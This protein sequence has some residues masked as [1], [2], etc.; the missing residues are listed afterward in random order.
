MRCRIITGEK[1]VADEPPRLFVARKLCK[2]GSIFQ[3]RL[4]D[5][6]EI[7][8]FIALVEDS[9]ETIGWARTEPWVEPNQDS[10]RAGPNALHWHT[11]EAFVARDYRW[12]GVA[13]FAAAGLVTTA[14]Q[15]DPDAAVF[16]PHMM[17]LAKKVGLRPVLFR[18]QGEGWVRA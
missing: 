16:H 15:D 10:W 4:I 11:L 7:D 3:R 18:E 13:T 8:G 12:R 17:L 6:E 14:F 5:G 2:P 1:F 9:G